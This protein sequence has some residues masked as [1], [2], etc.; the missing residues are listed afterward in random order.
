MSRALVDYVN[1]VPL[2]RRSSEDYILRRR[3]AVLYCERSEVA[4]GARQFR[5]VAGREPD[6]IC[7][8]AEDAAS[9]AVSAAGL[10]SPVIA[11]SDLRDRPD[12][13]VYL[14]G[15]H[16]RRK[17]IALAL[18]GIRHLC[19]AADPPYR[20]GRYRPGYLRDH[21]EPLED[22]FA[23]LADE[24]SRLTFAS[25]VRHRITGEHGYL[26]IADYPEYRHPLAHARPGDHVVDGGAFDG[27]TS[28]D[29]AR[30]AVG[31]RVYAF[32]PDVENQ[33]RIRER[34]DRARGG[35][36]ATQAA[37][38]AIEVVDAGLFDTRR[39]LRFSS[40]RGGSSA[41][42]PAASADVTIAAVDLDS[43]LR[44]RGDARC[45]LISLD[46]EGAERE[47][48]D[49]ARKTIARHRPVLQVSIYHTL[50]DLF[51]LP[52]HIHHEHRDY[53]FFVGHHNTYSTETDLY[54]VPKERL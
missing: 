20:E 38:G 45:D 17:G 22:V 52:L 51:E 29:F 16:E 47:A 5:S 12:L 4:D 15:A 33:R 30:A 13:L 27:E 40:G 53:M 23:L 8:H 10:P 2:Y 49:G 36:A 54:A 6:W 46:V 21:A 31:G 14:Y 24:E 43:F 3:P 25:V 39:T 35:D 48:L 18:A 42:T 1:D 34:L 32:E 28:F 7:L 26:R 9:L 41:I 37:A 50:A 44:E 11:R 19:F